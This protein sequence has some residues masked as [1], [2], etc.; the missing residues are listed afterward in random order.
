M[1]RTK[2]IRRTLAVAATVVGS[3][4]AASCGT[5]AVARPARESGKAALTSRMAEYVAGH[6]VSFTSVKPL[7][8]VQWTVVDA[9]ANFSSAVVAVYATHSV[10]PLTT[11]VSPQSKV[12]AMFSRYLS[13]G[14]NPEALYDRATVESVAIDGCRAT[15]VLELHYPGGRGL[16]YVSSWVRPFDR[17]VLAGGKREPG[18]RGAAASR[19]RL[20]ALTG[21]QYAPW[22]F[23]GDNR[24]GGVDTPCGI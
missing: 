17:T 21:T 24:V 15:V 9:Y 14:R 2:R 11:I 7:D 8:A 12:S 20:A 4:L 3:L 6:W 5:R 19:R 23:V 22:Q 16:H 1:T 13:A 18:D 10:A